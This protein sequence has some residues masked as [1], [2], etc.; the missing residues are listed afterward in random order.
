VR[1]GPVAGGS[2]HASGATR[3]PVIWAR[4]ALGGI[5]G[6]VETVVAVFNEGPDVTLGE[7]RVALTA[8]GQERRPPSLALQSRLQP[9]REDLLQAQDTPSKSCRTKRRGLWEAIGRLGGA[10]EQR[11]GR[12]MPTAGGPP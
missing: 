2:S 9:H 4:P 8:E 10:F 1:Q 6:H 11:S 3:G 7:L 12:L 5:E